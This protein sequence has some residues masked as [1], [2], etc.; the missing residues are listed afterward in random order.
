MSN[1]VQ[2]GTQHLFD[3]AEP[4][5]EAGI[6]DLETEHD[7][8]TADGGTQLIEGGVH[9]RRIEITAPRVSLQPADILG[10]FPAPGETDA[11][12]ERVA[13][14]ALRRR[15]LPWERASHTDD[16]PW[17]MLLLFTEDEVTVQRGTL[18]QFGRAY[19]GLDPSTAVSWIEVGRDVLRQTVPHPR[20]EL[21][22]LAH[23][24]RVSL[25]DQEGEK[26]D[27]GDI[28]MVLGNR[29]PE[30]RD[31]GAPTGV[32][33]IACLVSL[34]G[35]DLSRPWWPQAE[36]MVSE[37]LVPVPGA[38]GVRLGRV[39]ANGSLKPVLRG[40]TLDAAS[41]RPSTSPAGLL[42]HKLLLLHHWTFRSGEAGDFESRMTAL[43]SRGP[44]SG[45][46]EAFGAS[47]PGTAGF[48]SLDHRG[49]DGD[50]GKAMY[51]GPLVTAAT[52]NL[53]EDDVALSAD[54]LRVQLSADSEDISQAAAF[55]VG[56]L[57]ALAD[58]AFLRALVEWRRRRARRVAGGRVI[59]ALVA[60]KHLT[61][62]F[63]A[64]HFEAERMF[65]HPAEMFLNPM[66]SQLGAG[67]IDP[68]PIEQLRSDPTELMALGN[69]VAGL[70]ESLVGDLMGPSALAALN[71]EAHIGGLGSVFETGGG[72]AIT[73]DAAFDL[74]AV[75][76]DVLG[77][78]LNELE[79]ALADLQG[80]I[81][82]V[83]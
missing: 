42:L 13:H 17:M 33:H 29:L 34:E 50:P 77:A 82:E 79:V 23:V 47:L 11:L 59:T 37:S 20:D 78:R 7:V 44:N 39:M 55:E 67:V 57:M 27:D 24:R 16:S 10:M 58:P 64:R 68:S 70:N 12:T 21:P 60:Q 1:D 61:H 81:P 8:H 32:K 6:Y 4:P 31:A 51:R 72:I 9:S 35:E 54:A 3:R 80:V 30:P 2:P 15:T 45:G 38:G 52:A 63:D 19:D 76:P 36:V 65:E 25:R 46:V 83:P 74:Q 75:T 26:D 40:A 66:L 71:P 5:L 28:A 18:A 43:G 14:I 69:Q 62:L 56:R 49:R 22:Y 48:A 53:K 41:A 73:P